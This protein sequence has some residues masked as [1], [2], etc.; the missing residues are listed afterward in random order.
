MLLDQ[1]ISTKVGVS[2][3]DVREL[4]D[5]HRAAQRLKGLG[6]DP[7]ELSSRT[8]RAFGKQKVHSL[9]DPS[10]QG[11]AELTRDAGMKANEVKALA[12]TLAESGSDEMRR[13]RLARERQ[14]REPQIT[15]LQQGQT[16]GMYA[17]RLHQALQFLLKHP[18]EAFIERNPEKI[19]DYVEAIEAAQRR[20]REVVALQTS[21]TP[22]MPP[23]LGTSADEVQPS[24]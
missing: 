16:I 5:Q 4:R 13:E 21:G 14:A 23:P 20:L 6:V 15:A 3:K 18:I 22:V 11:V 24:A 1:E 17:R 12:A 9:D 7:D 2:I 8:L 10:Y 19:E